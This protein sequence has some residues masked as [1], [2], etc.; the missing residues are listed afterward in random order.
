MRGPV[1]RW[2]LSL[3]RRLHEEKA[4]HQAALQAVARKER[5]RADAVYQRDEA[6]QLVIDLRADIEAL[7]RVNAELMRSCPHDASELDHG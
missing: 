1:L 6:L 5:E 7:E 2:A 3:Q 4:A